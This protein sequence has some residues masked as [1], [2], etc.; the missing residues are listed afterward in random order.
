MTTTETRERGLDP[1][2][3]WSKAV[4]I[5]FSLFFV[6]YFFQLASFWPSIDEEQAA[7]GTA[8]G[9]IQ[10]GR[11][12]T[13]LFLR[14]ILPRPIV[15]FL[16]LALFGVCMSLGYLLLLRAHDV[17]EP[18]L[19]HY[20]AFPLFV[21][22]PT[23]FFLAN[24]SDLIAP[25][26]FA[27]LLCCGAMLCFRHIADECSGGM[28]GVAA[29]RL[30]GLAALQTLMGAM[31]TGTYQSFLFAL[32][33]LGLGLVITMAWKR[34]WSPGVILRTTGLLGILLASTLLTYLAIMWIFLELLGQRLSYVTGLLHVPE[35]WADPLRILGR[36]ALQAFKVYM[37]HDLVYGLP[38]WSFGLILIA[39][40]ISVATAKT[41]S[42]WS[43]RLL[44]AVALGA[45]AAPFALHPLS[46]GYLAYRSMV[47]V[48]SVMWMLA[49]A[50]LSSQRRT[51]VRITW[52]ALGFAWFQML[53]VF[54]VLQATDSLVGAHDRLLASAI[55]QRIL[56]EEPP[57]TAE[58]KFKV[59]FYGAKP[60]ETDY[61]RVPSE[62][63]GFSFFEW[64]GGNPYRIGRFMNLIGFDDIA[65][66]SDD[67][68]RHRLIPAFKGMPVWPARGSVRIVGD[69]T[70]VRLGEEPG[71]Y[72]K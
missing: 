19:A 42:R 23:W 35:L 43:R 69:A 15:P 29:R 17:K 51:V 8:G 49:M 53:S 2:G 14:F 59:D 40:F 3:P 44:L 56:D 60:F 16:P 20:A 48:P 9:W 4:S 34:G 70:L 45:L 68:E 55:Y 47:G 62:T 27:M 64:D 61:P 50:G 52:V 12:G 38:A 46:A 11:W 6:F 41:P 65:V 28:R 7:F 21:A 32:A 54:S 22:F 10:E 13:F 37:G 24:F 1:L 30:L 26:G 71:H 66:V 33:S 63:F 31:A 5:L 57:R 39:G 67:A 58:G 25:A 36:T 18:A 72:H